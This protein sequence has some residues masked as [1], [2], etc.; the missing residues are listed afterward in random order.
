VRFKIDEN[1]PREVVAMFETAGHEAATVSH[2]KPHVLQIFGRLL[3]IL[4]DHQLIGRL[5]IVDESG[6]RIRNEP[7]T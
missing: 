3:S 6:I 4:P 7:E 1:L 5:W 2:L